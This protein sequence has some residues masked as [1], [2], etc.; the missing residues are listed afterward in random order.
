[1]NTI[2]ELRQL[3]SMLKMQEREKAP[4]IFSSYLVPVLWFFC[5]ITIVASKKSYDAGLIH[6]Y[7]LI[8]I[9]MGLGILIAFYAIYKQTHKVWPIFNDYID[10]D[11]LRKRVQQLEKT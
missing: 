3:R 4:W 8:S 5:G 2:T 10:T 7:V 1:M 6:M 11:K 9:M